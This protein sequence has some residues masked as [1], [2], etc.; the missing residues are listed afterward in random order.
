ML[1]NKVWPLALAGISISMQNH[2]AH[3]DIKSHPIPQIA[4]TVEKCEPKIFDE[5]DRIGYQYERELMNPNVRAEAKQAATGVVLQGK[6]VIE[7]FDCGESKDLIT[8]HP[9]LPNKYFY[10]TFISCSELIKSTQH[11]IAWEPANDVSDTGPQ[12]GEWG[13]WWTVTDPK[14]LPPTW[15]VGRKSVKPVSTKPFA[16]KK[17]VTAPS[18]SVSDKSFRCRGDICEMDNKN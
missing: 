13:T 8:P 6:V 11:F 2:F 14:E 9:D 18:F 4:I 5:L 10:N 3:A 17:K 12:H 15:C 7:G 16:D 1:G